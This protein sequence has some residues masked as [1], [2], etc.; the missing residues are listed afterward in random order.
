MAA[1][2]GPAPV[3]LTGDPQTDWVIFLIGYVALL[4]F[5]YYWLTYF[6]LAREGFQRL[7]SMVVTAAIIFCVCMIAATSAHYQ[8][9]AAAPLA[10]LVGMAVAIFITEE[11]SRHIPAAVRRKVIA[12]D[13]KGEPFDSSK[14][15]I[16]HIVPFSRGGSHT[17]DNLRVITKRDNLR[18]GKRR[19]KFREI[20]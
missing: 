1:N 11:R 13:L 7:L 12:R 9:D 10:A 15:H 14:H 2:W 18:K 19:P 6:R 20:W 17:A 4:G 16:D 8:P 3:V 5:A